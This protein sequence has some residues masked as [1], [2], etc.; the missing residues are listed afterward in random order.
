[1]DKE[2]SADLESLLRS[3]G[4]DELV[5]RAEHAERV[6][7]ETES[8][9]LE[10]QERRGRI[11]QEM[12]TLEARGRQGDL[13]QQLAEQKSLLGNTLDKYAVMAVCH[14]LIVRVRQIYEEERQPAVLLAASNYLQEMTGGVYRRILMKMG[15]QELLA[16][17]RE[18]GPIGSSYL[19]RGTA[20]QLYLS[21]RLALSDAVSGQLK[22]PILLDDLF[23][24][25][26]HSRM[27]GALSVIKTVSQLHQV[28]M[29]T[30]HEH[31]AQAAMNKLSGCQIIRL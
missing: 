17:H 21:M 18:H 27:T 7:R 5:E 31:V 6:K 8:R 13:L 29:M 20:E 28:I 26:D 12:E 1:M 23:V 30:C 22:L 15:S 25:F 19:S 16:E 10:L 24:N 11:L 3:S 2:K 4:E 9:R 14:E